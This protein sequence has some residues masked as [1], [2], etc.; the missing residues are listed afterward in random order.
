MCQVLFNAPYLFRGI[1]AVI[2]LWLEEKTRHRLLFASDAKQ[3]AA[4]FDVLDLDLIPERL[5]GRRKD[6]D[7]DIPVFGVEPVGEAVA[8]KST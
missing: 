4:R 8:A 7:E 3:I 2:S 1:Y 6:R 5:G